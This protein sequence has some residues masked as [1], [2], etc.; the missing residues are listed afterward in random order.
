ML[1]LKLFSLNSTSE[2][3]HKIKKPPP[4]TRRNDFRVLSILGSGG[5]GTVKLVEPKQPKNPEKHHI[6]EEEELYAMK[7]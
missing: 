7:V 3:D 2:D 4:K 5:F 6:G 1:K